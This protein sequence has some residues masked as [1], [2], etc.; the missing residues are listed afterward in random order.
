MPEYNLPPLKEK[1]ENTIAP[2]EEFDP[3]TEDRWYRQIRIP[4]NKEIDA[5]EVGKPVTIELKGKV[6]MLESRQ[7]DKG[8]GRQ[9]FEVEVSS[10]EAYA[11]NEFSELADD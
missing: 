5:L 7:Q 3:V 4:A 1:T 2:M 11:E 6:I 9:E 10:V 8:K